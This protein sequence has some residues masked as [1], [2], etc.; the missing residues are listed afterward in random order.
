MPQ[1]GS[2]E[3]GSEDSL[4]VEALALAEGQVHVRRRAGRCS[5]KGQ[6]AGSGDGGWRCGRPTQSRPHVCR[7]RHCRC[8]R[9][10]RR[11]A[12]DCYASA[13]GGGAPGRVGDGA[14][15]PTTVARVSQCQ[16]CR[17]ATCCHGVAAGHV[18]GMQT[19]GREPA[20]VAHQA[21]VR[22]CH[23]HAP[24]HAQGRNYG[25][26]RAHTVAGALCTAT[27][28]GM[29]VEGPPFAPQQGAAAAA[30]QQRA[31]QRDCC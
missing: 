7:C 1:R 15:S 31:R 14:G 3:I 8:G 4:A 12:A 11:A 20:K 17:R 16:A 28:H 24:V 22:S 2:G 5:R 6:A 27:A 26:P 29:G 10:D 25:S 18:L 21:P 19:R 9:G 13:C 23:R 30:P